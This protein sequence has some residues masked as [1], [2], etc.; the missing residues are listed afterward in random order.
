MNPWVISAI[1]AT[2]IIQHLEINVTK[3]KVK[4]WINKQEK[5]IKGKALYSTI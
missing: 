4:K 3:K 1:K 5:N 2:C